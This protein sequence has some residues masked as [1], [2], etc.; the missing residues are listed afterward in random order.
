LY[1][2]IIKIVT[3]SLLLMVFYPRYLMF[4]SSHKLILNIYLN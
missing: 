4:L 2:K 1:Q 3:I